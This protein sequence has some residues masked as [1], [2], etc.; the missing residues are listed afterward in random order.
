M[1]VLGVFLVD[2]VETALA[3]HDLA[4]GGAFLNRCSYFHFLLA[5]FVEFEI[6]MRCQGRRGPR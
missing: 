5:Y 6:E 1:F 2:D 3:A 4:V